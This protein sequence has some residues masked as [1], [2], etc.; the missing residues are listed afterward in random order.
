MLFNSFH[1]FIFFIIFYSL[2]L[3]LEHKKQNYWLLIGSYFFYASWSWKFSFIIL[4]ITVVDFFCAL[5]IS[6]IKNRA[7]QK[8]LLS[9]SIIIN[10]AVL[11]FFKYSRFFLDNLHAGE[12]FFGLTLHPLTL[13]IILPVGI[14]FYIFRSMSYTIDVYRRTIA[15]TNHFGDY[16]L[17]V[18]FFPLLLAGPIERAGNLLP[19]IQK[20]R[21]ISKNNIQ[22]GLWLFFWGLFKKIF[23]ADNLAKLA[24][25]VFSP[26]AQI[27]GLQALLATY[28]YT[29]Q[30]YAD[31]SGYS[32]MARGLSKL[33]GFDI[34]LNFRFPYFV[35][36]PREFWRNWHISLSTWLRDYLYIPLGGNRGSNLKTYRNILLTMLLGGLWH[37]AAWNFV[38][39]GAYHGFLLIL[40]RLLV[41]I[42]SYGKDQNPHGSNFFTGLKMFLMFHLIAF[43][44]LMFRAD[45]CQQI[46][47][48]IQAMVFHFAPTYAT[49]KYYGLQIIF[50]TWVVFSV[51][52]LKY[53]RRDLLIVLKWPDYF[54][55]SFGVFIFYLTV[56]WGEFGA[57]Q[58][59]YLQF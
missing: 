55:L 22:E 11:G 31:F 54:R 18:S 20:T 24:D 16:A 35:T 23:M 34:S 14:S 33:M 50:F 45:S 44:W 52:F 13:Q 43:G 29:F 6:K 1:F 59:I 26:T 53:Q 37:G 27:S 57:R 2:Y 41:R 46:M 4:T 7:A 49:L 40:F 3:L 58:F 51:H 36:N 10:L 17:F 19:Q 47:T 21:S 28:A 39:W 32:D 30:I 12:R 56:I 25:Q 42:P 8:G 15:P 38:L 9:L 5:Y 48:M